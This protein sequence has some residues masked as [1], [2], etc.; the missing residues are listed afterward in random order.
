MSINLMGKRYLFFAISL[1]II[2]PGIIA[3]I[4]W[5]LP[6]S[7]DFK[8]GTFLEA[9]FASGK[10]P[11]PAAVVA[12]YDKT[13]GINDVTVASGGK[14]IL[15]I[16]ST[17][18]DDTA[19]AN[20][21]KQL[22][23]NFNDTVT[24]NRF[25][26]VGPSLGAEV[27][28]RA[29]LAVVVSSIVLILFMTY[30]CNVA[31]LAHDILVMLSLAAIGGHFWGWQVNTLFLTALLTVIAFSAQD[32]IVVFDRIRENSTI[33]RNL[34]YEKLVNHSVVQSLTRSINTQTMS[35]EFLLLALA[36]FGG[37]T[38]REFATLLL[39]GMFSGSYSSVFSAAPLL[40]LWEKQDW[41]NW[42]RR[43]PDQ[44]QLNA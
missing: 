17:V 43:K 24:A 25:D 30:A 11:E 28:Q 19:R 14:D 15:I 39:V 27:T 41:K 33:Y 1:L 32:T 12:F 2:L 44:A 3:I 23:S 5:G 18:L 26:S 16:R 4:A 36:L 10:A 8:G 20:V 29:I 9:K 42:F 37:L 38:L 34:D 22:S 13:L 7:I 40:V 35:V 21:L 6:M 31:A